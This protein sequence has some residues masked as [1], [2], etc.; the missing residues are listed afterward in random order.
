[1]QVEEIKHVLRSGVLLLLYGVAID[2][3]ITY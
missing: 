3:L 1:M 2:G